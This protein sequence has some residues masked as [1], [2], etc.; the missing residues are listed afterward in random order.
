MASGASRSFLLP[1]VL[2]NILSNAPCIP[3]ATVV[4]AGT[5]GYL[6]MWPTGQSQPLV[7]TL[8]R[9]PGEKANAAIVPAGTGGAISAYVTDAPT[10]S[11]T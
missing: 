2:R 11:W 1:S 6:T 5:L 4:P 7:S 3:N 8:N 10:S 9:R